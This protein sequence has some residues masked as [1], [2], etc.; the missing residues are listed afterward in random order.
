MRHTGSANGWHKDLGVNM[1]MI[2]ADLFYAWFIG[3]IQRSRLDMF[4]DQ[5]TAHFG[6]FMPVVE[7]GQREMLLSGLDDSCD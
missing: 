6:H 5:T 7:C 2:A 3:M 4:G 1:S